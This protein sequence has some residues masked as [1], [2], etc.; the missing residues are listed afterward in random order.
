M[1]IGISG[2]NGG[3]ADAYRRFELADI[4]AGLQKYRTLK[5]IAPQEVKPLYQKLITALEDLDR[6]LKR[7]SGLAEK[8]ED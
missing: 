3:I 4:A 2:S 5:D 7:E 6:N 8:I 1:A